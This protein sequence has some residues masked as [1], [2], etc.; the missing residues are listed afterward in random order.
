VQSSHHPGRLLEYGREALSP[1]CDQA[2]EYRHFRDPQD[3]GLFNYQIEKKAIK[4]VLMFAIHS[5]MKRSAFEGSGFE[6][7][8]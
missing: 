4:T 7:S 1:L 6:T 2:T 8:Q 3:E 5:L